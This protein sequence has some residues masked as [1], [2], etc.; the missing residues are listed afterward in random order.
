LA[1]L[2][3][4]LFSGN[5]RE[6]ADFYVEALG[7]EVLSVMTHGDQFGENAPNKDKVMHLSFIAAGATFYMTDDPLGLSGSSN[8]VALNLEFETH[9]RTREAYEKLSAGGQ[10]MHPLEKAFWGPLFGQFT[11]KF[12]V[13]W[14]ISSAT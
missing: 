13:Q 5:A 12:G 6:Q 14:M 4:Y 1:K 11:D 3:P 9:E 7:G 10:V 2:T 8:R